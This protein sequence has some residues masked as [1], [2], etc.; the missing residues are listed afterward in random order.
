[1]LC[2]V[3]LPV[4]VMCA[5]D[6]LGH[7]LHFAEERQTVTASK[8]TIQVQLQA[9]FVENGAVCVTGRATRFRVKV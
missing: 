6:N 2:K 5:H 7:N 1:V 8:D 4:G 9:F 3:E